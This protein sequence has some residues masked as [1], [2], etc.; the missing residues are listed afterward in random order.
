[1]AS[2]VSQFPPL[3]S[4]LSLRIVEKT[5]E[6]VRD[7]YVFPDDAKA[8][9]DT[10]LARL[11]DGAFNGLQTLP[12]LAREMT[13]ALH[14]VKAD[15]H[16]VAMAWL[17]PDDGTAADGLMDEWTRRLP[18]HNY[19]F[20]K[21][22]VL[23]GNVGYVN[24]REFAPAALGG[25]TA[26]AAMQL[27]AHTDALLFDLRDNGGGDDLVYFLM[28]YL[29]DRPEHVHTAKFRDHDAQNW[30]YAYVPGPRFGDRPVYIVNSRS[31]FSAGED[32]SYNLQ[33]LGRATIVGEQT[34]GGAHPVEFYR[35]PEL[36]LEL[37]IPN[38]CSE[39]PVSHAN[40][41]GAGVTPDIAAPAEEALDVAHEKALERLVAEAADDET[42]R[43][44]EWALDVLRLRKANYA[45]EPGA[46]AAC[47]GTYG[48]SV[49]VTMRGAGLAISWGGRRAHALAPLA[50]GRFE[51]DGGTQQVTF[52]VD[53]GT[54]V[55][56]VW[57]TE[58]GDEWRMDRRAD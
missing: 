1:M 9:S 16:L 14:S 49:E 33:Q 56:L 46:L 50:E 8:M 52:T 24:L 13:A 21:L 58:D 10:L 18:R 22:E 32:F 44:R 30:T 17:P 57:R 51:F 25:P 29:F 26:A 38:A 12:D 27:L 11:R 36:F 53:G 23:L 28:S 20:R 55:S 31:T 48:S 3:T 37:M 4:D 54:A 39:N 7:R 19:G 34:R 2:Q 15:L 42:R 6:T 43:T 45:P 41:E 35:F 47:L 40:W 5:A